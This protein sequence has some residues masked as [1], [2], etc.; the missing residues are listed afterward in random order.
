MKNTI[1]RV[2][3]S[4]RTHLQNDMIVQTVDREAELF[5]PSGIK[6]ALF[7]G[8][9]VIFVRAFVGNNAVRVAGEEVHDWDEK[10]AERT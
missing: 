2:M 6:S 10:D 5:V 1:A 7:C 9:A 4:Q 8:S 3:K